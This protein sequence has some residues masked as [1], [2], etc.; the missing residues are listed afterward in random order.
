MV[1]DLENKKDFF[2]ALA[3]LGLA[4]AFNLGIAF[5]AGIALAYA[6]KSDKIRI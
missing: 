6:L 1:Q 3:M 2:V 5:L 4:L